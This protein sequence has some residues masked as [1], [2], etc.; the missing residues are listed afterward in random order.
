MIDVNSG[1]TTMDWKSTQERINM[2]QKHPGDDEPGT[3]LASGP[4][5]EARMAGHLMATP[6]AGPKPS[7]TLVAMQRAAHQLLDRPLVLDDPVALALLDSAEAQSLRDN[8]G[9]LRHQ[10]S[11]D[12]RGAVVVRGRLADDVWLEA[13]GRGIG[14]YVI[15]GAGLDTSAYRQP[16][17]AGRIFEVDLPAM[18]QWKQARLQAAGIALPPSLR[19]VPVDFERVGLAQGLALAGFDT[20]APAI[21]SWLGV[22]MYLDLAAVQQTLRFIGGCAKGSAVLLEYALPLQGLPPAVRTA[23]EQLIAQIAERGEP[24]KSFFEPAA[25][26]AMLTASG[27]SN[28][29]AWTPEELNQ[30]YLA[31]RCDG[32]RIGGVSTR[33][34]LATV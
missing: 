3:L 18:Q 4:G 34:V 16:G 33:L 13:N 2:C 31:N 19:F 7:A 11:L 6:N 15:L 22:T 8:P 5:R 24:W 20:D 26:S 29:H 25:L 1:S 21:F 32:L 27:F 23:M 17:M 14:Q 30:R 12:L 10:A 9:S 28:C